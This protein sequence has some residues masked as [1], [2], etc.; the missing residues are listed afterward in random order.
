MKIFP[1]LTS[2]SYKL[3]LLRDDCYTEDNAIFCTHVLNFH[4]MCL[5]ITSVSVNTLGPI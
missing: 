3:L 1:Q 2:V 4:F 5:A